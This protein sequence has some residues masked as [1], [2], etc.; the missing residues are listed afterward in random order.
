[1]IPTIPIFWKKLSRRPHARIYALCAIV[2]PASWVTHDTQGVSD[3]RTDKF[4]DI[5]PLN[6]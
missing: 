2:I 3:D 4:S 6:M 5:S 1:M